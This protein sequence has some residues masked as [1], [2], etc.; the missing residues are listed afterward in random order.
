MLAG[1]KPE[2]QAE[3]ATEKPE[4][5]PKYYNGKVVCVNNGERPRYWTVGK[6]YECVDGVLIPNGVEKNSIFINYRSLDDINKRC[7]AK[8]IKLKE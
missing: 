3:K 8:F 6:I 4:E 2:A 7:R 1:Y 5:K